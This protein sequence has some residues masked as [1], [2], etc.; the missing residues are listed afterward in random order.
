MKVSI[1][2]LG[3]IG[4][5][6][7]NMY[8]YETETSAVIVDCGVKFA[9]ASDPGVDLI[10]PDFSYLETIKNK[11]KYVVVS[12]AHEDHM[13]GLP[14]LL[15]KYPLDIAACKFSMDIISHKLKEWNI[16]VEKVYLK[17]AEPL[18]VGD[19]NISFIP[20][21]HSIHGTGVILIE[22]GGVFSALHASDYKI[23]FSPL[24]GSPFMLKPFLDLGDSGLDCLVADS[25]N[26]LTQGFTGSE[27]NVIKGLEKIFIENSG[28]IFFTTFASNT[29]RIGSVISLAEKYGRKVALEG[30]SLNKNI[31]TARQNGLLKINENTLVQRKRIEKN[32]DDKICVIAT[33]SQGEA[34]SVVSK[35][36]R[37][38]YGNISIRQGDLFVFSSRIIPGN[39][40]NLITVMNNI[41]SLGGRWVDVDIDSSIHSSGHASIEDMKLFLKLLRPK[42]LLPVHGE[43]MHLQGHKEIGVQCGMAD[44]NIIIIKNGE[45]CCFIDNEFQGVE[46]IPYGKNFVDGKGDF[47]LNSDELRDRKRLAYEGAV[48]VYIKPDFKSGRLDNDPVVAFVGFGEGARDTGNIVGFIKANVETQLFERF[49]K[50][51]WQVFITKLVRKYFK[52]LMGRRPI[53]SVIIGDD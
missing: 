25:T 21:S 9:S 4:E 42:Y 1:G 43:A 8:I 5:I 41:V 47:I 6:G 50:D 39:E 17:Y 15:S 34:A 48:F 33:G 13:G 46:A 32:D 28:R 11:L 31:E 3:G 2:A 45:K 19:F 14:F 30:T 18:S 53:T 26:A 49:S 51:G 29:E 16:S 52:R 7:M 40:Q 38:D 22:A 36:A 44:E 37:N 20:I 10:I 27:R 24:S 23:D 35:I 12:H